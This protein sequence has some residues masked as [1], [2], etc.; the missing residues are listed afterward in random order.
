[1]EECFLHYTSVGT[2]EKL[3]S[4]RSTSA[5]DTILNAARIRKN[6][7]AIALAVCFN[8]TE[9]PQIRFH[10]TCRSMFTMKRDCKKKITSQKRKFSVAGVVVQHQVLVVNVVNRKRMHLLQK[11]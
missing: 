2:E 10:K 1:M 6:E 11:S 9:Y 8:E 5:W 3:L 7:K 4:L